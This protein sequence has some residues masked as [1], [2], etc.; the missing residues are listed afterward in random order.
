MPV[1]FCQD[2]VHLLSGNVFIFHEHQ[3]DVLPLSGEFQLVLR[4]VVFEGGNLWMHSNRPL[5]AF[6]IDRD[7]IITQSAIKGS[8]IRLVSAKN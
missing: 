6:R 8:R 5:A 1:F 7:P 4:E 2:A 3:K